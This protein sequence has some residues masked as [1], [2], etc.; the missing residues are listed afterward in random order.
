MDSEITCP[1]GL[2]GEIR[3]L[4][5]KDEA[6]FTDPRL[7]K[8]GRIISE[9]CKRCWEKTLD[10]GPY[11][12]PDG[13]VDWNQVLQGDAYWM[14]MQIRKAS[15]GELYEFSDQCRNCRSRVEWSVNL[16]TDLVMKKLP[17]ASEE[18]FKAGLPM[19]TTLE[20]GRAVHFRLLLMNDNQAI[21]NLKETRKLPWR[22]AAVAQRL[23]SVEGVGDTKFEL[24]RFMEDL[25]A[26]EADL[27][28]EKVE[29]ADC[30]VDTD[31]TITCDK[32]FYDQVITLPFEASF[33]RRRKRSK[34]SGR[35][36]ENG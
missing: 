5:V 33:F 34:G 35:S 13:N 26:G 20:D 9:L 17:E 10:I 25:D 36:A 31:I 15:Y 11:D 1:S 23:L 3:K 29:A 19:E 27:L 2:K 24:I 28:E 30:G 6:M 22:Y 16:D 21:S 12:F 8:S 7:I 18:A 32:C 4:K 14:F